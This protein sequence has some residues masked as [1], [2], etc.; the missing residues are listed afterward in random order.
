MLIRTQE[1]LK[2]IIE[3]GEC[4]FIDFKRQFSQ[5]TDDLIHDV[6][7]LANAEANGRR[8]LVFGVSDDREIV[9][10]ENCQNRKNQAAIIDTLRNAHFNHLPTVRLTTIVCDQHEIDIL[11]IENSP[12]KPFYITRDFHRPPR[13]PVRAGV[14]YSRNGDTNTPRN[15]C[16][17]SVKIDKMYRQR[18]GLDLNPM[19]RF[20]I[21]LKDKKH[22]KY[23]YNE[24]GQL[25]FYYAPNPEFTVTFSERERKESFE[26]PWVLC[27]PDSSA[28]SNN[29]YLKYHST[30]IGEAIV[31][32]CDGARFVT[33]LPDR[34]YFSKEEGVG[35]FSFYYTQGS[36]K[37]LLNEMIADVYEGYNGEYLQGSFAVIGPETDPEHL[38]KEDYENNSGQFTYYIV[39]Y[40]TKTTHRVV[41]NESVELHAT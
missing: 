9:G 26:E 8:F 10:V 4:D 6:I 24:N 25:F 7:C 34:V 20:E 40:S 21:Y 18:Y 35:V 19:D 27:F 23:G 1:D 12:D 11:T 16:P 15:Q 38:I 3:A 32:W 36:L 31:V 39:R 2:R 5:N 41:G 28:S 33:V 29:V 14:P 22:W 37:H 30:V 17:D 13:P